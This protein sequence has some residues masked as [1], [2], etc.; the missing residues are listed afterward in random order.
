MNKTLLAGLLLTMVM[1]A[2]ALFGP[3]LAPH[4]LDDQVEISF[5]I[6]EAGEGDLI[7]PPVAPGE[8]YP[9]GTDRNG[10]DILTKLLHGAKYTIFLATAVALARVAIGGIVGMFLGYYGK[11]DAAKKKRGGMWNVLNGIPVFLV[12]WFVMVGVSMNPS[13]SPFNLALLIGAV[14]IVIGVPTVISTVKDKTL[15]IRDRQFVLASRSLG[16][17]HWTMLRSHVF[18]HLKESFLILFVNEVILTLTLFGQLAIFNIFV[19]GTTMT[20]DPVEY[21][22]RTNEWAGLIGAARNGI[23]IHQWVLF[24]PLG[25][26]V[27]LIV[28]FYLISKGLESAYRSKYSKY[29]HI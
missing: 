16:A 3:A 29:A 17:G 14:L 8:Q 28:G 20:V 1:L 5:F 21:I 24:F 9:F 15:E 4:G 23:Y 12:V 25:T 6:N 10:Y 19:G 27:A 2:A 7:A 13:A 18:P 22:S 26:Y 11:V